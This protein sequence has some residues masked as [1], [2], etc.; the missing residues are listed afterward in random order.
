MRGFR[1]WQDWA[2]LALAAWISVSPAVFPL[3]GES[4]GV[5]AAGIA[6]ELLALITL[7][8]PF[9]LA[10]EFIRLLMAAFTLIIPWI[11]GFGGGA[12][13]NLQLASLA[14]LGLTVAST[15][16][17]LRWRTYCRHASHNAHRRTGPPR[18]SGE[19]G[20]RPTARHDEC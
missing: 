10:H 20:T 11:F 4:A 2:S 5:T 7:V 19:S 15:A 18:A 1:R 6:L 12:A 13:V 16:T 9:S 8:S 3:T 17:I 14:L